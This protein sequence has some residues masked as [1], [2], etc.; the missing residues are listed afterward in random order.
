MGI[1]IKT[2]RE[3]R[4]NVASLP[5]ICSSP[6]TKTPTLVARLM[7]LDLLPDG[8]SSSPRPSSTLDIAPLIRP[9][10]HASRTPHHRSSSGRK[11]CSDAVEYS[12]RGTRSLPETTRMSLGRRSDVDHHNRWS[13]QVNKENNT[14]RTV[15]EDFDFS[16]F[17]KELKCS[18]SEDGT[19][20]SPSHYARQI[21]KQ[22]KEKV[23]RRVGIKDITNT[24]RS[25]SEQGSTNKDQTYKPR[26]PPRNSRSVIED[27]SPSCTPRLKFQADTSKIRSPHCPEAPSGWSNHSGE[28]IWKKPD[29]CSSN[30]A[31]ISSSLKL[32][33]VDRRAV[34]LAATEFT[35]NKQEEQ[36]VRPASK[37]TRTNHM[38]NDTVGD[39]RCETTA[40]G[41][42]KRGVAPTTAIAAA[43]AAVLPVKKDP[44]PPATKIPHKQV[45]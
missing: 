9:S 15:G 22:V 25:R 35:R 39:R 44:S 45:Y 11:S 1:Q 14:S 4:S 12:G 30:S 40:F 38:N 5:D 3:K 2:G 20:R 37:T 42:K 24:V 31:Q 28:V 43:S 26:K 19:G 36:F 34:R 17:R 7:G 10:I 27:A 29:H 21:V 18:L 8:T 13:L 32:G 16:R 23:S 6:G 33:S 41:I